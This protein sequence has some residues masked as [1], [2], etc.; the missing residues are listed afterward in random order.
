M[1]ERAA[2]HALTERLG[3]STTAYALLTTLSAH[4]TRVTQ[5]EVADLLGLSKSSVSRQIDAAIGAGHLRVSDSA[6]SR[7]DKSVELTAAGRRIV[8]EGDVL[9]ENLL[10]GG[11]DAA[12]SDP[13]IADAIRAL[14]AIA[15]RL[16]RL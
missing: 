4:E 10:P 1:L 13:D 14:E 9:V 2:D 3:I 5:Q 7:R 11:A 6:P 15:A 16:A 8:A 12:A